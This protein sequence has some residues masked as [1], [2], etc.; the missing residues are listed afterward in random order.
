MTKTPILLVY[1]TGCPACHFYCQLVRIRQSVGELQLVDARSGHPVMA[2]IS[3]AGL[4][5]DQGMVLKLDDQ[6]YYAADAIHVLSLISQ[7]NGLFNRLNAWLFS[8]K[9]LARLLYPVLRSCRN[10][11]LKLL[12]RRKVNNLQRDIDPFF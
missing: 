11:L 4:D 2:Q 3:A 7:R 9:Q 8:H 6:L 10:L 1:D 12:R 5:I